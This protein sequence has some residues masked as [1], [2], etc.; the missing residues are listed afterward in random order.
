MVP[1]RGSAIQISSWVYQMKFRY[2][3]VFS[4][5]DTLKPPVPEESIQSLSSYPT[6]IVQQHA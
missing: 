3:Y 5:E 6:A 1:V 4:Y 2:R